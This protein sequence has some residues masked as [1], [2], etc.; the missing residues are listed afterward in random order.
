MTKGPE[1]ELLQLAAFGELRALFPS[2]QIHIELV[3]P[4]VPK[5]RQATQSGFHFDPG[6][7]FQAA[8]CSGKQCIIRTMLFKLLCFWDVKLPCHQ[9]VYLEIDL[10]RNGM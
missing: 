6:K 7:S 9:E 2:V 5:S 3:G 1:K 4:E 10:S 8:S